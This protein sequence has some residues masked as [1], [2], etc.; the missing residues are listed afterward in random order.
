MNKKI[1]A[2]MAVGVVIAALS[3]CG[4]T[5]DLEDDSM[6]IISG[7]AETSD[8]VDETQ[9]AQNDN[10][11]G[12]SDAD[13]EEVT[14]T[15][16]NSATTVTE[17]VVDYEALGIKEYEYPSEFS[18]GNNLETA[19]TELALSYENFDRESVGGEIWEETFIAKFI[20]NSRSSFDY[21]DMVSE[22][23]NGEISAAELNY[24]QYSLTGIELDFSAYA[25]INRYDAASALNYGLISGY[26]Y[27]YTDN[28]MIVTADFEV[29]HDGTDSMEKREIIVKLVK[30]PYSCF[31]GY[32]V[33]QIKSA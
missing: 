27:E 3:S 18:M 7:T 5:K 2:A 33:V 15:A 11:A 28:G 4:Q 22:E 10:I 17:K 32:S 23:N 20:Q 19:I 29:G 31:D 12:S 8:S 30:N 14:D 25:D 16:D 24:I 21:L 26:V 13:L 9:E 6:D 1:A